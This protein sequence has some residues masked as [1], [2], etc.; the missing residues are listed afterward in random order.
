MTLQRTPPQTRSRNALRE[1]NTVSNIADSI[2]AADATNTIL[3]PSA[4]RNTSASMEDQLLEAQERLHSLQQNYK[5]KL[6]VGSLLR[7]NSHVYLHNNPISLNQKN[8]IPLV[9]IKV[10]NEKLTCGYIQ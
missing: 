4:A 3:D 10:Q 7:Q 5:M 6:A 9:A 8:L 1:P 2:A